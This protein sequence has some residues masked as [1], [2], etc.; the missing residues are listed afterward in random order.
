MA[1]VSESGPINTFTDL[2]SYIA[3][4]EVKGFTNAELNEAI[5][6]VGN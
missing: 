3:P 5:T 6:W 2:F 1:I 4:G